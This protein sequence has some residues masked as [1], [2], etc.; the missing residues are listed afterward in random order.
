MTS[1]L[2][3]FTFIPEDQE[4][5]LADLDVVGI[6]IPRPKA[7]AITAYGTKDQIVHLFQMGYDVDC[8]ELNDQLKRE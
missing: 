2:Y 6:H 4:H 5:A 7:A 8:W 3:E 1:S